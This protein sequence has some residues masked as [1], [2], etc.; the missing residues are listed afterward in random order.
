MST[1]AL[2]FHPEAV[3][4]ARLAR[5]WYAARNPKAAGAFMA[6][7]DHAIEQ[8]QAHPQGWPLWVHGTRRYPLR[9]FPYLVVYQATAERITVLAVAH[10]KRRPGFWKSR[11]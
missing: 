10:A 6:E 11:L 9:R 5:L 8:I 7:L 3:M 2:A 1:P 4:D